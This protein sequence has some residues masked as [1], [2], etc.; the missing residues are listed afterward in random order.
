MYNPQ[1]NIFM[2]V[3]N[4][5][6]FN[7]AAREL[8]L[9]PPAVAKQINALEEHLHLTLF[10]RTY[11]G[12]TLTKAGESLYR[13]AEFIIQYSK[14]AVSR[15]ACAEEGSDTIRIAT[16]PMAPAQTLTNMWKEIH[17]LCPDLKFQLV[18]HENTIEQVNEILSNLGKNV[19]LVVGY[20]DEN[21]LRRWK[22]RALQR[23]V[24]PVCCAVS[25]YSE[26][27]EKDRLSME[28]LHGK[29]LMMIRRGW[30]SYLD[31]LR[32]DIQQNHSDIRIRDFDLFKLDI[33]NHCQENDVFAIAFRQWENVHPLIKILP[34]DWDYMV[35]YGFLYPRICAANVRRFLKVQQENLPD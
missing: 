26:L 29:E 30:N 22:C 12:L 20:Y 31:A 6:S 11:A 23:S 10:H 18:S 1:L 4:T 15:A 25:I 17:E 5:R 34:V 33:F 21:Y 14:D 16:S 13:D 19:D 28:D 9:T 35:P 3:A 24:E 27:A 32:D 2:V 8:Y 7:K